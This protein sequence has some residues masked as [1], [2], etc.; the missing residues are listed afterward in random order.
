M[1]CDHVSERK[2]EPLDEARQLFADDLLLGKT[3]RDASLLMM[4]WISG[5]LGV[6]ENSEG[7]ESRK[8]GVIGAISTVGYR[9]WVGEKN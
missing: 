2:R 6:V 5:L 7:C 3:T 4:R 9:L 8:L 1:T